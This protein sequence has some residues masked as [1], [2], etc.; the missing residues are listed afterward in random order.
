MLLAQI[1]TEAIN[2][3][4]TGPTA[5]TAAGLLALVLGWL[6]I[7]HLPD[8]DKQIKELLAAQ[9]A[10]REASEERQKER[11]REHAAELK[12]MMELHS[13]ERELDRQARHDVVNRFQ[14]GMAEMARQYSESIKEMEKQHREDAQLDRSAFLERNNAV[15]QAVNVQTDVIRAEIR[16]GMV[17]QCRWFEH[18]QKQSD[19]NHK[20]SEHDHERSEAEHERSKQ[21]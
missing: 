10:E 7:K 15:V 4:W 20:R 12:N 2:T 13:K 3:G 9:Q 6:F 18:M 8:K 14:V 19:D 1:P 5:L 11:D 16:S 17:G 21:R